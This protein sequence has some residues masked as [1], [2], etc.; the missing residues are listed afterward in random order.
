VPHPWPKFP[1]FSSTFPLLSPSLGRILVPRVIENRGG[2]RGETLH[3][4]SRGCWPLRPLSHIRFCA[5][6]GEGVRI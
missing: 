3:Q 2:R 4:L 1:R 6:S 5:S